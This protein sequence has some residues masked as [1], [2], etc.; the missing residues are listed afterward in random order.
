M[1]QY[2]TFQK[3]KK[4]KKEENMLKQIILLGFAIFNVQAYAA[5][6]L[7]I[8]ALEGRD[9]VAYQVDGKAIRGDGF[10]LSKYKGMDYLFTCKDHKETFD[11]NPEKYIPQF[12][13]WC[14]FGMSVGKK[15]HADT[16][17]FVVYGGKLYVNVNQD[18]LKK[19]KDDLAENVKKA[20]ANRTKI[21]NIDEGSL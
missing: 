12:G 6:E 20:E 3:L 5:D 4:Y 19:L 14:A 2:S 1:E 16:E 8:Q 11:K 18:I 21:K 13:G 9:P 15:F 17:A 10:I 7:D